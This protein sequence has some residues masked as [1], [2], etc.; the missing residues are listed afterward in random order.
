MGGVKLRLER[1]LSIFFYYT[2][3]ECYAMQIF[4]SG[5]TDTERCFGNSGLSYQMT[6]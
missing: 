2:K 1:S 6:Q 3:T 5:V 4:A